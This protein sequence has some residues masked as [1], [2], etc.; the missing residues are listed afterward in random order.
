MVTNIIYF[1]FA[2]FAFEARKTADTILAQIPY[3]EKKKV[4]L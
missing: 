3:F 2:T 4:G 1:E